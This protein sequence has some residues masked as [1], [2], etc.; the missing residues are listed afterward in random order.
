MSKKLSGVLCPSLWTP[1]VELKN[2]FVHFKGR[3]FGA[4]EP[5]AKGK[6]LPK[7]ALVLSSALVAV[8]GLVDIHVH[9]NG[10]G[11]FQDNTD[12]AFA[13]ISNTSARGGATSVVA[14]MSVSSD[15]KDMKKFK[16]IV[17]RLR[18]FDAAGA[19]FIGLHLEG[20]YINPERRGSFSDYFMRPFKA[21]EFDAIL[22]VCGDILRKIT[23]A[24]ELPGADKLID[25]VT[26]RTNA[27]VSLGHSVA[28]F[29]LAAR[30]FQH[31]RV[32]QATHCF[33]AMVPLHHR[34]PGL[35]GAALLDRRVST[36]MIPDGHH[37]KGP[38]IDMIYRLKGRDRTII[39][40]DGNAATGLPEGSE[41]LTL[42]G[43]AVIR[44]DAVYI[45]GTDTLAGSNLLMSDALRSAQTLGHVPFSDA[46]T[47]CTANAAAAIHMEAHVGSIAPGLLADMCVLKRNGDVALTIRDGKVV[48]KSEK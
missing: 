15:D 19:R 18:R 40:T 10:G 14:T 39:I 27:E 7:D 48:Y 20:P 1:E 41:V 6:A 2:V 13:A 26:R 16:Q 31:P 22:D 35:L 9:G 30:F 33:N 25:A 23:I 21:G 28:D 32:R 44:N 46:L 8:P 36:E 3:L 29:D 42:G 38:I 4:L 11:D 37:L 12:A 34:K 17:N 47:M 5:W 24:P 43:P 45:K